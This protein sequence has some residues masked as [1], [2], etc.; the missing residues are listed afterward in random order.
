MIIFIIC[1]C[2]L[3]FIMGFLFAVVQDSG[4]T[5]ASILNIILGLVSTFLV[6]VIFFGIKGEDYFKPVHRDGD[7][8]VYR[9][10]QFGKIDTVLYIINKDTVYYGE[11]K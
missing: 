9:D 6:F 7:N 3:W 2:T 4:D 1:L 11:V 8:V 5:G 10:T